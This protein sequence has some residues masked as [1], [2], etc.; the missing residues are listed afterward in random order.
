MI[1]CPKCGFELTEAADFCPMCGANLKES[2]QGT[3]SGEKICPRCGTIMRAGFIV[4]KDSP[5]SL[6]TLGSGIYWTPREAG[7]MGE[8]VAVKAYACLQ[9]GY[10]EHYARYL[11]KDRNTI[12]S[13]PTTFSR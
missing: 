9:C 13:A 8:R 10:I 6:W 11:D 4:E 5:L 1:S 3:S 2:P 7:V 12:L